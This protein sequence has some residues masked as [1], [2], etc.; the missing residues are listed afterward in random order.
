MATIASVVV[1]VP[2]GVPGNIAAVAPGH[3]VTAAGAMPP[4]GGVFTDT[5]NMALAVPQEFVTV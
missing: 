5:C 1:H 3:S 2:A 4:R